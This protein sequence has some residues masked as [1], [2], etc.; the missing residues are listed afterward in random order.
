MRGEVTI[1]HYYFISQ[2]RA[3]HTYLN[4][5]GSSIGIIGA[6]PIPDGKGNNTYLVLCM[7]GDDTY[8]LYQVHNYY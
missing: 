1:I 5:F 6:A 7:L 2:G 8:G 3:G 4:W